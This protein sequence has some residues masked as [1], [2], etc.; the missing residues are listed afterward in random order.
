[1]KPS[2]VKTVRKNYVFFTK[3]KSTVTS[4]PPLRQLYYWWVILTF[5]R[6]GLRYVQVLKLWCSI[7]SYIH[8]L[9]RWRQ[10]QSNCEF[11]VDCK[12]RRD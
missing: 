10:I 3:L 6:Y 7:D 1:M 12:R 5:F 11:A 2:A 8:W 9:I 4:L